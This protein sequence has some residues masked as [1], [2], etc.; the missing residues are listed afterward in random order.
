[1]PKNA[2]KQTASLAASRDPEVG[3]N[4]VWALKRLCDQLELVQVT[5]ARRRGWT[6]QQIA[7]A[8]NVTRQAVHK[9]Y[10]HHIEEEH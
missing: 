7:D 2:T 1:M 10:A 6:W 5:N 3:L 9:R 8:L 4:A